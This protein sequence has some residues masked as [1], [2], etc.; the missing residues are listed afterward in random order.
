MKIDDIKRDT[1][2]IECDCG[3]YCER[4]PCNEEELKLY[5]CG[6]EYECCARAF[7]CKVC[8]KRYAGEAPAPDIDW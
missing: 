1:E 5:N 2:A 3:G 4:V 6:R 8:G 7:V